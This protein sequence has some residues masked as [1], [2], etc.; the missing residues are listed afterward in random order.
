MIYL[1]SNHN[2]HDDQVADVV[3]HLSNSDEY[4][5]LMD[6]EFQE[7][8]PQ[9]NSLEWSGSWMDWEASGVDVE[10]MSWVTDWVEENTPVYWQD[11]EPVMDEDDDEVPAEWLT[12]YPSGVTYCDGCGT[13]LILMADDD[14]EGGEDRD[15]H[16]RGECREYR[17][18]NGR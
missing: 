2:S 14:G 8:F 9:Y 12:D 1:S 7:A 13:K 16:T 15:T 3:S 4:R 11:G 18:R 17:E 5:E 6:G 10:Y